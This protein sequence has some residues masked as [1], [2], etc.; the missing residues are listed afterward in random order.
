[1]YMIDFSLQNRLEVILKIIA[2]GFVK[3]EAAY[4][5]SSWNRLDFIATVVTVVDLIPGISTEAR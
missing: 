2:F 4:F 5:R 1:M 3:G